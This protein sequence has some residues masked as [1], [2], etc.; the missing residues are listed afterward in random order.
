MLAS[1]RGQ[2]DARLAAS[3][4]VTGSVAE[5][6][7]EFTAA[8]KPGDTAYKIGPLDVLEVSVF[9]VPELS[10]SVQVADTGTVNLPLVGDVDVSGRTA[11]QVERDLTAKL[12]AKYLQKPQVTVYVKEYNSQRVTVE[13]AVKRPG[14]YPIRSKASL[15]QFIAT[16]EGLDPSADSTIV[17]FRHNDGR[18]SS[19][20]FDL[21]DIRAGRTP[22]PAIQSGDVIVAGSSVMKETFNN[23]IKLLPAAGLF[24]LL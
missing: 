2:A 13:G 5:T 21:G 8:A 17:I 22:D 16:A 11:Q 23:F 18:R 3:Q 12:G 24:A 6:A 1:T 20:R 9:Q 7:D 19:A 15:L 10:K 14:V 4:E